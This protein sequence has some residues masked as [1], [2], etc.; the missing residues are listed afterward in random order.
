MANFKDSNSDQGVFISVIPSKQIDPGSF[1]ETVQLLVDNVLD[2]SDFEADYT[3]DLG[4]ASAYPPSVLLKIILA[5]YHRGITSSRKIENLCRYNTLF[6]ALSGFLTPD[7]STI[8]AF[9]SKA[10]ERIET[11]FVEIVMECN[12][13]DLISGDVFAIDGTKLSSKDRKS[14]V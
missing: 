2:L 11:L 13:L 10:P 12:E 4:G 6:M 7:H 3:N 1:E 8:A 9:V 14:V 5:A